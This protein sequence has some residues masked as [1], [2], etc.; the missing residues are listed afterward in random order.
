LN[1]PKSCHFLDAG[2]VEAADLIGRAGAKA[3]HDAGGE[4]RGEVADCGV[5]VQ[6]AFHD[7]PTVFGGQCGVGLPG[8]VGGHE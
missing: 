2:H 5:V 7:E 6:F 1:E 3:G 8:Q 4:N